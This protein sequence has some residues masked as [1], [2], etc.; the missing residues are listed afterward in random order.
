MVTMRIR[1]FVLLVSLFVSLADSATVFAQPHWSF[2][3]VIRAASP[4]VRDKDGWSRNPIDSYILQQLQKNNLQ[5]SPTASSDALIRRVTLD[6][7]PC[8]TLMSFSVTNGP[9]PMNE[10]STDFSRHLIMGSD[11]PDPG[12]TSVTTAIRTDI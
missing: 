2:Q 6:P 1:D 7:L 5:Q 3:R 12:S 8:L 10:L 4:V 11:G 9:M